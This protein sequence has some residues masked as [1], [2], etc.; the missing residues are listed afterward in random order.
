[1]TVSFWQL[2]YSALTTAFLPFRIIHCSHC[3]AKFV[4]LTDSLQKVAVQHDE[5]G[6][7]IEAVSS[8]EMIYWYKSCIIMTSVIYCVAAALLKIT[9]LIFCLHVFIEKFFCISCY[10]L[11][12]ITAGNAVT[13][14]HS[15]IWNSSPIA[16]EWTDNSRQ[17]L[18]QHWSSSSICQSTEYCDWCCH[19]HCASSCHLAAPHQH[20][21]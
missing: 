5:V 14:I 4:L 7:H 2:L 16:Y 15:L 21:H 12:A 13:D 9:I 11:I 20:N 8:A 18:Q 6:H 1:M 3:C 10:I 19:A 17:S